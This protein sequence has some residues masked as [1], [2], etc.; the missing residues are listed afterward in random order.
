[1]AWFADYEMLPAPPE[2]SA[3]CAGVARSLWMFAGRV[4]RWLRFKTCCGNAETPD[5]P[6][7]GAR[8]SGRTQ[9]GGY[10]PLEKRR[11]G[12]YVAKTDL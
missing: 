4:N 12:R 6:G 3:G 1:M 11:K 2:C 5:T 7:L 8:Q 9:L 10:G